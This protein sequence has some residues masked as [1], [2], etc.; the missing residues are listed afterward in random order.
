[1]MN[2]RLE[3]FLENVSKGIVHSPY[4]SNFVDIEK[5]ID[6]SLASRIQEVMSELSGDIITKL[7]DEFESHGLARDGHKIVKGFAEGV[8][9]E[10]GKDKNEEEKGS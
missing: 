4:Y 1:M 8:E 7:A 10:D 6:D 2:G 3:K 9:D 5:V